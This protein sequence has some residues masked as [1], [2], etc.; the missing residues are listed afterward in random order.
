MKHRL[1]FITTICIFLLLIAGSLVVN[2]D[3]GL[4]CSDW[5]LCGGKV[6]PPLE[7]KVIIEYS[8]RMLSM[9]VG[10]LIAVNV[11]VAWRKRKASPLAA[12]LTFVALLLLVMVAVTGGVNV[13]LKLPPGFTAVDG[14]EAM[15][16]FSTFALISTI[17]FAEH[18]KRQGAFHPDKDVKSLYKPALTATIATLLQVML[19]LFFEHS[20][21]GKIWLQDEYRLLNSLISSKQIAEGIGYAHMF[22]TFIVSGAI[23]LL[24]FHAVN[25]KKL[26]RSTTVLAGLLGLQIL[27]GFVALISRLAIYSAIIHLAL[28]ALMIAVCVFTVAQA[29][30]GVDLLKP[31]PKADTDSDDRYIEK[32]IS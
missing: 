10:L 8:H 15:L 1:P 7:G 14:T 9:I 13:L 27:A 5:P 17:T 21:A 4:A 18:K 31:N 12:K 24:H 3:A 16:L 23:L 25:K 6:I 19:G 20:K 29:R 32:N 22:V 28:S 26:T 2:F 30:M 11:F